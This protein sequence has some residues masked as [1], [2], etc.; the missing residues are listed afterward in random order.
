MSE[1]QWF[2]EAPGSGNEIVAR[3]LAG[4]QTADESTHVGMKDGS[5]KPHDVWAVDYRFVADLFLAAREFHF[6]FKVFNRNG[7]SVPIRDV[8]KLVSDWLRG[9]PSAEVIRA[10]EALESLIG[11]KYPTS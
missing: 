9:K 1:Y 7:N 6:R 4:R 11:K 2:V 3:M 10:K 5:G 8:T